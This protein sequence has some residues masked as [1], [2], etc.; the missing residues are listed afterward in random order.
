M[1]DHLIVPFLGIAGFEKEVRHV[2][3]SGG[4][5]SKSSF[6]HHNWGID[7]IIGFHL[8]NEILTVIF[9]KQKIWVVAA[10]RMRLRVN[11][12]HEKV[13]L[14]VGKHTGK[15][16]FFYLTVT[17]QK[18][19]EVVFWPGVKTVGIEVK[20]F[21]SICLIG[22]FSA[23]QFRSGVDL[24]VAPLRYIASSCDKFAAEARVDVVTR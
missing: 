4:L 23:Y 1:P 12:L 2:A 3:R 19:E 21:L 18:R 22:L 8:D 17:Q 15:V 14:V 10:N 24:I 5:L 16:D 11:V 13:G 6:C 20:T 7:L 9:L